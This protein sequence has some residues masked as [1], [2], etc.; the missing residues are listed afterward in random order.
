MYYS[1][2]YAARDR[3]FGIRGDQHGFR[4]S[5]VWMDRWMSRFLTLYVP[6]NIP[7]K[8]TV[9][10]CRHLFRFESEVSDL[11]MTW[12]TAR[13]PSVMVEGREVILRWDPVLWEDAPTDRV[14]VCVPVAWRV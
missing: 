11:P 6:D 2:L 10:D 9:E 4:E 14:S 7:A 5:H 12:G 3:T 8:V 13:P 1:R